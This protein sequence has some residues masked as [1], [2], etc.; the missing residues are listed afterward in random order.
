MKNLGDK[1]ILPL[2]IILSISVGRAMADAREI[3]DAF[4][5]SS[6]LDNPSY[7]PDTRLYGFEISELSGM[8][9]VNDDF[10]IGYNL[11]YALSDVRS[12]RKCSII[13]GVI[14]NLRFDEKDEFA[15][16]VDFFVE[17]WLAGR[18][19]ERQNSLQLRF[20]T[21]ASNKANW[22][23]KPFE[24]VRLENGR[25]LIL[26]N[27]AGSMSYRLVVADQASLQYYLRRIKAIIENEASNIV[28]KSSEEILDLIRSKKD[29]VFSGYIIERFS[30]LVFG[31]QASIGEA[32]N[33]AIVLTELMG[34]K[35]VPKPVS[36]LVT[37]TLHRYFSD[38]F[39]LTSSTRTKLT[40]KLVEIASGD[41]LDEVEQALTLIVPLVQN[42]KINIEPYLKAEMLP[43]LRQNYRLLARKRLSEKGREKFE[44]L[45][46]GFV[47]QDRIS[48]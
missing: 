17:E 9:A 13:Y 38:E 2:I 41:N 3:V 25:R 20:Y 14:Q 46:G 19:D 26:S 31:N 21:K 7:G 8:Q 23:E 32:D 24:N 5:N 35:Y 43:N 36:G 1:L 10:V 48:K 34:T 33:K 12:N 28:D 45:V 42:E 29:R 4:K 39:L 16:Q 44:R 37:G 11:A 15:K 30:G 18:S 47:E 22:N 6:S 27:C 40:K